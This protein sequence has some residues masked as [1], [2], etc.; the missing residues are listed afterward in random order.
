MTAPRRAA[1]RRD[2]TLDPTHF[3]TLIDDLQRAGFVE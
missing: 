3:T 2:W 1:P